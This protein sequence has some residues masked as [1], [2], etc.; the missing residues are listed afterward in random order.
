MAWTSMH[1]AVGMGCA[2]VLTGTACLVLRRGWRFIPAGMTL[3]GLWALI[4]DSPRIFREDFP[5]LPF[6]AILGDKHLERLL[7]S[8]GDLFFFH[9]SLDHQP[10]EYALHGLLLIVLFYNLAIGLLWH[11]ERRQ[12]NSVPNRNWRAHRAVRRRCTRHRATS[13]GPEPQR[14]ATYC[15]DQGD[16][17]DAEAF[18]IERD[19][20][21]DSPV[22]G[23]IGAGDSYPRTG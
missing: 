9:S 19:P 10:H 1:F 4:P 17:D 8:F 15:A 20:D 16:P 5:S 14:T 6:A 2:G 12:R 23:K 7:H 22:V 13:S 11:L 21:P 3:G 18:T